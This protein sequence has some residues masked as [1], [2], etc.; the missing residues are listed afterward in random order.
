MLSSYSHNWWIGLRAKGDVG[1]VDYS[2]DNGAL[3]YYTHW[4]RNYP[5]DLIYFFNPFKIPPNTLL[6]VLHPTS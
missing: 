3:L 2:W 4:D 1:G 5:G 6:N